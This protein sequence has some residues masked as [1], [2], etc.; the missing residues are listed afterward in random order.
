MA[1]PDP[2][3]AAVRRAVRS[4]LVTT[5]PA[6]STVAA[7]SGGADS[8]ALLAALAWEA[9]RNDRRAAA[10]TVDHGLHPGSAAQA[11]AVVA[12]A[13]ALGVPCTVLTVTPDSANES[14]AR[15]ARYAALDAA[16]PEAVAVLLGHTRDDQAESVLLGL[17]RGSGTRSLAGMPTTRGRYVRPF[18]DLTRDT[19]ERAC[20]ALGLTPWDDPANA[21]PRYARTRVRHAVLPVLEA[22][23]G[24]GVSAALA[25]TAALLRA[26]ADLLDRLTD[27]AWPDPAAPLDTT[28]LATLPDAIRTRVLRRAAIAAGASA[29][30]LTA[31]HVAGI[32]ALVTG[33]HGQ[34]GVDL[35]GGLAAVRVCDTVAFRRPS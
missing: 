6:S 11:E 5:P 35:P 30:G 27:E 22:E 16:H 8:L 25:R 32:D 1:G 23:L 17:A 29:T 15:R 4:V 19:T 13:A 12:Q 28:A 24:P 14:D 34:R 3:V 21:D 26:D 20:A 33:W 2:A 10:V 7:V 31:A 9:P 18:L